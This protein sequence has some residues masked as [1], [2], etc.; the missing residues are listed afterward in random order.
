MRDEFGSSRIPVI[1]SA[2]GENGFMGPTGATG[3]TGPSG[4][5]ITG[6]SGPIGKSVLY[7]LGISQDTVRIIYLTTPTTYFDLS[8]VQGPTGNSS[9]GI[10]SVGYTGFTSDAVFPVQSSTGLTLY[11]KSVTL[12]GEITGS[13]NSGNLVIQ[14][15]AGTFVGSLVPNT[16]LFIGLTLG[17]DDYYNIISALGTQYYERNFS[18]KTF[19]SLENIFYGFKESGTSYNF[20]YLID[21]TT[22]SNYPGLTLSINSSFYGVTFSSLNVE[23]ATYIVNNYYLKY[24]VSYDKILSNSGFTTE[25]INFNTSREFTRKIGSTTFIPLNE[26]IGSCCYCNTNGDRFCTDYMSKSYCINVMNGS[27]NSIPCYLRYNTEDCYPGGA[28]CVNNKCIACS[29]DKCQSMGGLFIQGENCS[30]IGACPD[31]CGI[32][33][34]CCCVNGEP[35]P[36]TA[37]LCE[38]ISNAKYVNSPCQNVDCCKVGYLGACCINKVCFD[39]YSAK[40][41]SDAGGIYQGVGSACISDLINCC[42]DP[43]LPTN[44]LPVT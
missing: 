20:N 28:C 31:R 7:A 16:L 33:L 25:V 3:P 2:I 43:T 11:F 32:T 44:E 30:S 18:G 38:E 15:T 4:D 6:A 22:N 27:W 8:G 21:Y 12:K 39:Y 35:F 10:Y 29:R 42:T 13:Y 24:G 41:C 9:F 37:S 5:Y 17:G 14:N 34:G 26:R 1:S 19:S 23:G 36:L 40:E